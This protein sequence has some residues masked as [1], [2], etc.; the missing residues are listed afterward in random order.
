MSQAA[1]TGVSDAPGRALLTL[2]TLLL[3]NDLPAS[4]ESGST[5]RRPLHSVEALPVH[6]SNQGTRVS[7]TADVSALG[8][9]ALLR[10]SPRLYVGPGGGT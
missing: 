9:P 10:M 4:L 7:T 1:S 2:S 6:R 8:R 5:S 3:R